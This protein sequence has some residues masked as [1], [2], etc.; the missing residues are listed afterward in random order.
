MH[1]KGQSNE[2]FDPQFISSFVPIWAPDKQAKVYSNSVS[3]S[4]R[5]S[6]FSI[7]KTDSAQYPTVQIKKKKLSWNI[8]AKIKI[9]ALF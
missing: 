8:S 3:I 4:L 9:V 6:N 1:L 7:E 2:I 5:Y